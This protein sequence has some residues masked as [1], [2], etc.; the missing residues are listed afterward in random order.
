MKLPGFAVVL[1]LRDPAKFQEVMEEAWQKA[2]GLV[3]FTRGQKA[4]PGL[5]IRNSRPSWHSLHQFVFLGGGRRGQERGRH[6]LQ[7][8][9]GVGRGR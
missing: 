3:N 9:A 2:I 5:I 8:P 7:F 1:Q 6:S 4:L